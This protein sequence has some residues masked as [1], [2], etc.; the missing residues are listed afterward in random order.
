MPAPTAVT[1]ADL[2]EGTGNR[3]FSAQ[4]TQAG[5]YLVVGIQVE[6][7]ASSASFTPSATGVTFPGSA[8]A[9]SGT[10]NGNSRGRAIVWVG[11]D[12]AGG[13]RTV[14]ITAT[15]GHSYRARLTVV[16]GSTG[17]GGSGADA[18]AQT[19]SVTRTG[20]NSMIFMGVTDWSTGAVGSPAWTPGGST[21]ASQ[22]GTNAT[23]IFGRWDDSGSSG[24]ASHGISSPCYT[25][26]SVVAL[27]MLGTAGGATV[28][29]TQPI[30]A[31]M[32]A[33]TQ[34]GSW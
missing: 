5:D 24:A 14:T 9:D 15:A 11:S 26:P 22:Q 3:S 27:E 34:A 19:V 2:V 21:T 1:S 30:V 33:A 20:N 4:T 16:R 18:A 25:T 32:L 28:V 7:G 29:P 6:D 8:N 17:P 23:Y 13:S 12:A 31:P 10:A